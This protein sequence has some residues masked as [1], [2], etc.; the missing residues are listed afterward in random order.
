M[1]IHICKYTYTYLCICINLS[2][3]WYVYTGNHVYGKGVFGS[4]INEQDEI[5]L[6]IDKNQRLFDRN[7]RIKNYGNTKEISNV[8]EEKDIKTLP[9]K[10]RYI[11]VCICICTYKYVYTCTHIDVNTYIHIYMYTH[12][13]V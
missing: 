4:L 7:L 12:I 5:Q 10:T 13:Y 1:H 3:Y 2:I 9:L 11:Y 6:S 8:I